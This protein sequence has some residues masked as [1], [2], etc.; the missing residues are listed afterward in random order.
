MTWQQIVRMG[1]QMATVHSAIAGPFRQSFA[2]SIYFFM[3]VNNGT[4]VSISA[5]SRCPSGGGMGGGKGGS[6]GRS[7][8]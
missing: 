7:D 4:R 3:F 5:P 6:S 8:R 2:G 1:K